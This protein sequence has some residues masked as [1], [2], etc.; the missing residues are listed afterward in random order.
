MDAL[1]FTRH[2]KSAAVVAALEEHSRTVR[3]SYT[4]RL[5]AYA[6]E[7]GAGWA[8]PKHRHLWCGWFAGWAFSK[9]GHYIV[10]GQCVDLGL[11]RGLGTYVFPS[12]YRFTDADK[13][14]QAGLEAPDPVPPEELERG[15]VVIIGTDR[16]GLDSGDHVTLARGG[17]NDAGDFPTVEGNG[18]GKLGNGEH[19]RGVITREQNL[20]D[21]AR[22]WRPTLE[23]FEGDFLEELEELDRGDLVPLEEGGRG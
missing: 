14:A 23:W 9:V 2:I 17:P 3:S 15:D 5:K 7:S 8:W 22:V 13:W 16:T 18:T 20:E 12:G 10:P 6:R 19:G 11:R 1:E 21:V 4:D